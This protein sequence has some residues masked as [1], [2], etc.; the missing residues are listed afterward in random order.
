MAENMSEKTNSEKIAENAQKA[1]LNKTQGLLSQLNSKI[2]N[3]VNAQEKMAYGLLGYSRKLSDINSTLNK[4]FAGNWLV[5]QESVFNNV[6]RLLQSGIVYNVEQ[7]GF[8]QTLSDELGAQFQANNAALTRLV[9]LQRE[10][11]S[12]NRLALEYSLKEFLNQSFENSQYIVNSFQRVSEALIEAQSLMTSQNAVAL[13]STIQKWLGSLESV[14]MSSGTIGALATA[15][16]QLG[17]GDVSGLAQ[18][19]IGNLIMMGASQAGLSY[20]DLLT[21]GVTGEDAD[22]LIKGIV[23]YIISMGDQS[24]NVV[25]SEYAKIFGI[26]VSDIVAA[27]NLAQETTLDTIEASGLHT[28][29]NYLLDNYGSLVPYA[30]KISNF[31]DNILTGTANNIAENNYLLYSLSNLVS[32]IGADLLDG[33][34]V[35]GFNVGTVAK[36]MPYITVLPKLVEEIKNGTVN[37]SQAA[38]DTL[39]K[40]TGETGLWGFGKLV[41][42][43]FKEGGIS[44]LLT[45]FSIVGS[46]EDTMMRNMYNSLSGVESSQKIITSGY[47]LGLRGTGETTSQTSYFGDQESDLKN[48]VKSSLEKTE[49]EIAELKENYIEE[50]EI[51]ALMKSFIEDLATPFVK[52]ELTPQW[53][54]ADLATQLNSD[55]IAKEEELIGVTL[56]NNDNTIKDSIV[57]T[58]DIFKEDVKKAL[59]DM[60]TTLSE[61]RDGVSIIPVT[62]FATYTKLIEGGNVV[63]IGAND[64]TTYVRDMLT[65]TAVNT[66]NIFLLLN[67]VL[68]ET[69]IDRGV[70]DL[71]GSENPF[72]NRYG[73]LFTVPG[74]IAAGG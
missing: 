60:S 7:R 52:N 27:R 69:A 39:N 42:N 5:K 56:I 45:G 73:D 6:S 29:I 55:L 37:I 49:A 51:F 50:Q 11:S 30:Q 38:G 32:G 13:E 4:A 14:G 18:S 71:F 24:S 9:N 19:G 10:D 53:V 48:Q 33:T 57:T 35:F 63:E 3:Y 64:T 72:T 62:P 25:K 40:L 74:S 15:I 47:G 21:R 54:T 36:A 61:I 1:A 65:I 67:N 31:G 26:N 2:E 70:M 41:K 68:N 23:N 34:Q 17:S 20:A 58:V 43:L 16:G 66:E 8:L 59:S 22:K 44:N 12:E 46:L 28:D